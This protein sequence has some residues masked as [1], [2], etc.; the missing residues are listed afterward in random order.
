M[1]K[2]KGMTSRIAAMLLSAMLAAGSVPGIVFASEPQW[3]PGRYPETAAEGSYDAWESG[4]T[5]GLQEGN[6]ETVNDGSA[7]EYG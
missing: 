4:M 6:Q 1:K 5:D 3:D 7:D 2:V